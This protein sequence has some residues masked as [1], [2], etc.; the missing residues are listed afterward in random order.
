MCTYSGGVKHCAYLISG[1]AESIVISLSSIDLGS[2]DL[3]AKV[4]P[5]YTIPTNTSEQNSLLP[6][7]RN[8]RSYDFSTVG[9]EDDVV[10]INGP[11][12][13]ES[14]VLIT[15][16]APAAVALSI[17]VS[18]TEST[19]TLQKGIPTNSFVA[20]K[21]MQYFK[22]YVED[23]S[24]SLQITLTSRS[25]DPDLM[26]S[27][28][29]PRAI[30]SSQNMLSC[31]NYTWRSASYNSDRIL[32]S[33][34]EPCSADTTTMYVN[35]DT[36]N[37][38][39]SYRPGFMYITVAGYTMSK[40]IITVSVVGE[41]ITLLPGKP[42]LATTSQE[43]ICSTRDEETGACDVEHSDINK[44]VNLAYFTVVIP[45]TA[46]SSTEIGKDRTSGNL[47]LALKPECTWN[48]TSTHV[49]QDGYIL[50]D[51]DWYNGRMCK[52]GC[53]CDP[54]R[55][56]VQS[57]VASRCT[58][59]DRYPSEINDHYDAS[60][61]VASTGSSFFI[62]YDPFDPRNGY[63]DP[64][65]H[66]ENCVYY[67]AVTGSF[68]KEYTEKGTSFTITAA[69]SDD[70]MLIP[71]QTDTSKTAADGVRLHAIDSITDGTDGK[72][73]EFC[74]TNR[75]VQEKL[76]VYLEQCYGD[77]NLF[78]CSEEGQACD[79]S[80]L[81][82][83]ANWA[84]KTNGL[85]TCSK[86]AHGD[87]RCAPETAP[88]TSHQSLT[89]P[90]SYGNVYTWVAGA[91]AEYDI[92]MLT[93]RDG[94]HQQA[95][96]V[97]GRGGTHQGDKDPLI[98]ADVKLRSVSVTWTPSLVVFP[99]MKQP[100]FT[101]NVNYKIMAVSMSNV[102]DR[103]G[104][105]RY[106]TVCGAQHVLASH[107]P[108]TVKVY[109][110]PSPP[111][112]TTTMTHSLPELKGG[113]IYRV[114]VYAECDYTCLK[115]ITE[116]AGMELDIRCSGDNGEECQPIQYMYAYT[117]VL[118][119]EDTVIGE[120]DEDNTFIDDLITIAFSVS[121]V[122]VVVLFI[123]GA[124]YVRRK[125]H[126]DATKYEITEMVDLDMWTSTHAAPSQVITQMKRQ[127]ALTSPVLDDGGLEE[128]SGDPMASSSPLTRGLLNLSAPT[129]HSGVVYSPMMTSDD[130]SS[131]AV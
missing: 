81:P 88:S 86:S 107:G 25:G 116:T 130:D 97:Q 11:F 24:A 110:V 29:F 47:M 21:G 44:R 20:Q 105:H 94:G 31:T 85:E 112:E 101:P 53:D 123:F 45:P 59:R 126:A 50:T 109:E 68:N 93:T 113:R 17:L 77:S 64:N 49:N 102:H 117:D 5:L 22:F 46:Q 120:D 34:D 90:L 111:H 40:F 36:C 89:V 9:K 78:A 2:A 12:A 69:A 60:M 56:Y 119:Q 76:I 84:Y 6:N 95:I 96:L 37:P 125:Q 65:E 75:N 122:V 99:G 54:L 62:Q 39:T 127:T 87:E 73:Y 79:M 14:I 4:L 63:C 115:E 74:N 128:S 104:Q 1:Q 91:G 42:Q 52:L 121:I 114:M 124:Q 19:I 7:P 3:Y 129:H 43:F 10:H 72:Y 27:M 57:C 98:E 108:S 18:T 70:V 61:T 28:D 32:I 41:H 38:A 23:S 13:N 33:P 83:E 66:Q 106:D 30:C 100:A 15:I 80:V 103:D 58:V 82:N 131:S 55:V 16:N 48:D 26:A 51:D 92:K 118:T 35:R 8:S 67:I 71:C